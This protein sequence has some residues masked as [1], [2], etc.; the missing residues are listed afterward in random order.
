MPHAVEQDDDELNSLLQGANVDQI[1]QDIGSRDLD[2]GEKANDAQ[3]FEDIGDDDLADD[4]D[5]VAPVIT[6]TNG[7]PPEE[8]NDDLDALFNGG[9]DPFDDL[10][11]SRDQ[12]S[13]GPEE[14]QSQQPTNTQNL[15]GNLHPSQLDVD[16]SLSSTAALDSSFTQDHSKATQDTEISDDDEDVREQRMLFAQAQRDRDERQRRGDN[17][18]DLPPAPQTNAE[19]F[20]VIWPQF[21]A[22]KPPRF[23]ELLPGKRAHYLS[24]TPLKPPKPV[25]PTKV[26]L[27]IEQDQEISFRLPGPAVLP[28]LTRQAEASAQGIVLTDDQEPQAEIS[29]DDEDG[30]VA[31]GDPSDVGGY[32]WQD[33]VAI[34]QDWN[35][36]DGSSSAD[37]DEPSQSDENARDEHDD[38]FL[39]L[40]PDHDASP[41]PSK[42]RK[43]ADEHP[44][45]LQVLHDLNA[46]YED[47][48]QMTARLA[49]KVRLDMND[50]LMLIDT[51]QASPSR[52][53]KQKLGG[54]ARG[55]AG[56]FTKSISH[57]YNISN[58]EAYDMLKENRQSKIRSTLG[59]I[60][61]EHSLP[62]VRLQYPQYK[63]KLTP[64]EAR[65]F[66]RPHFQPD[67]GLVNFEKLKHQKRKHL[68]GRE[69]QDIFA[70]TEDLSQGDNSNVLLLEYSEEY[71]AMLS[72]FGM[73]NRLINYY[74]RK[75]DIDI[76]RPRNE[77]GD[78]EVLLPQDKSPFSMFGDVDP[79]ENTPTIQNAMYRA[80][81]F[82][83]D[84]KSRDFLLAS[85]KTGSHGRKWFLKNIENLHVVGQQF[86]SVEVPGTHS[87]KVTDA[88]KRR[89][90]ML[91]FRLFRRHKR[92]K[93]EMILKH[94]PGSDVAQNRSKMREFMEYDKDRGWLP[95]GNDVPDE[96]AIR[97]WIKPE[98]IC[99]LESMQVG[100]RQLQDAGYN[101]DENDVEEYE[102]NDDQAHTLDQQLAPWQTTKNFLNATQGK[103]ML[104]L[105]G[106]GEPTGRGEAFSFI[107]TSM[108]GGFKEIGE[109]VE[110]RL[111]AKSRKELGG[112]TYNV[113][114]QQ[115]LYN[116]AIRRIWE[117]QRTSLSSTV[118]H[119][120][121]DMEGAEDRV[122]NGSF[123]RGR[124]PSSALPGS[125]RLDESASVLS[126]TSVGSQSGKV[127]RI[128]RQT[129]DRYGELQHTEEIIR[130]P[131]VIR[132]YMKRRRQ[133]QIENMKYDYHRS[134]IR[135]AIAY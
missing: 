7:A 25:Q 122:V 101:K 62:A 121:V 26:T 127:L 133:R 8:G 104:K 41:R 66:H 70:K 135:C 71:P 18:H 96:N 27:E 21:E 16:T 82:K 31:S 99:L 102:D 30:S 106:E 23:S 134:T 28:F 52:D 80:P 24:K 5:A 103:A 74:R 79:G 109:S 110:D 100:D 126:R 81:V 47:P 113:A 72:D 77:I 64:R 14:G 19:L 63:V 58:D 37:G 49:K 93:N 13:P 120:D 128:T 55:P 131:K 88:S 22:D 54:L 50:P 91:S 90:R 92:L 51:L 73:G 11:N 42:K 36:P 29:E 17:A 38:L 53:R 83:H 85:S 119:E 132:E 61:I 10:F 86:P 44:R 130:D 69:T 108:K 35:I 1:L 75:D 118:E 125:S 89:L 129:K 39:E 107:R 2:I 117:K 95:K 97:S 20:S 84:P 112:H 46:T 123:S 68:K 6:T 67:P 94:N 98:D 40:D 124:T 59:S 65:S 115:Q 111:N 114:L 87:R 116:D 4:E 33:L 3:D 48:E 15:N 60:A 76:T 57:R 9:D 43:R 78:T 45:P 56:D 12:A 105:H 32:K 34:C